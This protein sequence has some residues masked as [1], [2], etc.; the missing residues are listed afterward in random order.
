MADSRVEK[1]AEALKF[2]GIPFSPTVSRK[3]AQTALEASGYPDDLAAA[4]KARDEARRDERAMEQEMRAARQQAEAAE[5]ERDDLKARWEKDNLC[6]ICPY[7]M[8]IQD[9]MRRLQRALAAAQ[10]K[11][12]WQGQIGELAGKLEAAEKELAEWQDR[13]NGAELV[14]QEAI[15]RAQFAEDQEQAAI[16]RAKAAEAGLKQAREALVEVVMP[17]EVIAGENRV[18]RGFYRKRGLSDD[19]L[20][21]INAAIA[22][23]RTALAALSSSGGEQT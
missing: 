4:E 11:V 20:A 14:E 13:A 17:L 2:G 16:A 6:G 7:R 8:S 3:A 15:Q 19:L 12:E 10:P 21:D 5:E 18:A 23:V 1:A 9:E 22:T